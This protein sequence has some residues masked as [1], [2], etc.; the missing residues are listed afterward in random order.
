MRWVFAVLLMV[1]AAAAMG[2][3]PQQDELTRKQLAMLHAEAQFFAALAEAA[4]SEL[5]KLKA[6]PCKTEGGG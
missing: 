5:D 6:Q 3:V 4:K 2:Q 1:A